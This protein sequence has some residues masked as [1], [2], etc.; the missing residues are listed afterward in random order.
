MWTESI[1][2]YI[3]MYVNYFTLQMLVDRFLFIF[4]IHQSALKAQVIYLSRM[5]KANKCIYP[6]TTVVAMQC[7][8]NEICKMLWLIKSFTVWGSWRNSN[9]TNCSSFVFFLPLRN[10]V[11][12]RVQPV[13][14]QPLSAQRHML[15]LA[16]TLRMPMSNRYVGL[17]SKPELCTNI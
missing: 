2:G 15:P 7:T 8:G 17:C 6:Q 14:L 5:M 9:A 4:Y 3:H 11:W 1:R 13:W 10:N 12:D 16:G